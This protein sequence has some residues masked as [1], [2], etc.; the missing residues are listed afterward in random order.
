MDNL[1]NPSVS[2]GSGTLVCAICGREVALEA[3]R[4]DEAGTAVHQECYAQKMKL[5][6]GTE[7]G[8]GVV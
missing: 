4:T 8:R 6:D 2:N 1:G 7:D 5:A 3:A